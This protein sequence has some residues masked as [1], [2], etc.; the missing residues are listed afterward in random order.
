MTEPFPLIE[1][2]G[3]P[4]ERGRQYGR[5]AAARIRK[6]IAHYT[7]QLAR[8]NLDRDG[9]ASLVRAYTPVIESFDPTH[10][11][12]MRGIATGA[13]VDLADIVLLNAR[14]ESYC[15][16][17][18]RGHGSVRESGNSRAAVQPRRRI[19]DVGRAAARWAAPHA[20]VDG[21]ADRAEAVTGRLAKNAGPRASRRPRI[22]LVHPGIGTWCRRCDRRRAASCRRAVSTPSTP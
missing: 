1:V 9:I 16:R 15:P 3:P 12:E 4:H 20:Q 19:G 21:F 10:L 14:T 8:L 6:G 13:D 11:E 7:A 18:A 5:Q 22:D 17:C 2:S